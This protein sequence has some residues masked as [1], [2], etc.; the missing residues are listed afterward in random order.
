[1]HL[2]YADAYARYLKMKGEEVVSVSGSDE[3]GTPIEVEAIKLRVQPRELADSNHERMLRLLNDYMVELDNYTRT[4]SPE[5]VRFVQEIYS[6]I[7]SNGYVYA[8]PVLLPY[9]HKDMRFLPDRFV[10]GVCP[11]CGY[12]EAR[13]DQCDGCGR[14]LEPTELKDARCVICGSPP[15]L[16][17]STHWFFDLP[18]LAGELKKYIDENDRLPDNARNF[19][20]KWL[21][22]G[23]RPRPLTRDNRWGIPAPFPGAEGKTIYVWMEAVLGYVSA[24]KEWAKASGDEKA[25]SAFWNDGA[26]KSVYFIGKDNIPFHTII[27]PALL[28]AARE[29]YVLPWQV[30]STEFI[31]FEGQ[32]FSKSR[33]VG[34]WMDEA[35]KVA[36][37]EYWRFVLMSI[38]P[39]GRDANFSWAEL[40]K[41]VNNDLNDVVGNYV[42]RTLTFLS[43]NFSGQVPHPGELGSPERDLLNFMSEASRRYIHLMDSFD[44]REATR[45][46]VELARKGNE[47]LSVMEPWAKLRSDRTEAATV[48]YTAVQAVHSI[49]LML[50]PA[51]PRSSAALCDMLGLGHDPLK[52]GFRKLGAEALP[53]GHKLNRPRPLFTKVRTLPA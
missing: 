14:L 37:P 36:D 21:E 20:K 19:S 40:E 9:C 46:P 10:E 31:L 8:R 23:L 12:A 18:K 42:H 38:R 35:E 1:M 2:I 25:F 7:H 52:V 17:E 32:K 50:Y 47:F 53:P 45:Q 3:H 26:T 44:I 34:V 4:E 28:L 5:H 33:R 15:V 51:L 6:R 48:M 22:E 30:S 11:H 13:G 39:E 29:G 43:S 27:F 41:I 24:V 49:A 16:K